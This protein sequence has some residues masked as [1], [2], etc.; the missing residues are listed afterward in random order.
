[1]ALFYSLAGSL[2]ARL[3]RRVLFDA[4]DFAGE[5]HEDEILYRIGPFNILKT[6][7]S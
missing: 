7:E 3:T 6:E 2:N 1:M 5:E 4:A